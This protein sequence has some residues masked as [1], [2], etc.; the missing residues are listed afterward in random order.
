MKRRALKDKKDCSF[1]SSAKRLKEILKI[2]N[3]FKS[4]LQKWII[5]HLTFIQYPISNDYITVKF[6]DGTV[7]VKTEP[8]KKVILPV[9]VCELHI[10]ML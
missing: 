8:L 3:T 6:Y 5:Y 4:Y 7:G 10:D 2:N 1:L 9:S